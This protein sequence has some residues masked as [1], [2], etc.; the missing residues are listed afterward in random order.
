VYTE[1]DPGV[2]NGNPRSVVTLASRTFTALTT[3]G[4][5]TRR[6]KVEVPI[7]NRGPVPVQVG[8]LLTYKSGGGF[9]PA[10][11]NKWPVTFKSQHDL[12]SWWK[13]K[14]ALVFSLNSVSPNTAIVVYASLVG[15]SPYPLG[16]SGGSGQDGGLNASVPK[17]Y[18]IPPSY[19]FSVWFLYTAPSAVKNA[20]HYIMSY[21]KAPVGAQTGPVVSAF[22]IQ[23]V[24]IGN[25]A[26]PSDNWSFACTPDWTRLTPL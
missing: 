8:A 5:I 18:S 26:S 23:Y 12:T 13:N 14:D 17:G 11:N 19:G 16:P 15:G 4:E 3:A 22:G 10:P 25:V 24:M 20:P 6:R 9:L 1:C 21:L 7:L 2:Q